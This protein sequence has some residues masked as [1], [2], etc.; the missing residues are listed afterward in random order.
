MSKD[1]AR[2]FRKAWKEKH[3]IVLPSYDA[4]EENEAQVMQAFS[5]Q[6]NVTQKSR[7]DIA[8]QQRDNLK[9]ENAELKEQGNILLKLWDDYYKDELPNTNKVWEA[10]EV[11]RKALTPKQ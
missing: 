4:N 6:E 7:A 11:A 2:E 9:A 8:C 1:K 10:M 3:P 5:D